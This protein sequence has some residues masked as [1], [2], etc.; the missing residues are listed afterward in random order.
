MSLIS[1]DESTAL[2]RA[3]EAVE[4]ATAGE[5]VVAIVAKSD[6]YSYP[7]ALFASA[8][9]AG[10]GWLVYW[11]LPTISATFVFAGQVVLW[12]AFWWLSGLPWPARTLAGRQQLDLAVDAR[13][14]QVFFERG[15]TETKDRSGVLIFVSE[16]E[17]RVQILADR[18]IHEQV[19]NERWSQE[20]QTV[21]AAIR[22]GHAADG[23]QTVVRE[24]GTLLA[25][26]FPPRGENPNEL[27]NE[28]VRY[29]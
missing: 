8:S 9:A 13:A 24:V 26:A 23:L 1:E 5:L 25:Q 4:T 2:S 12:V 15:L 3:I 27:P 7:R 11:S 16:L 6:D 21:I 28:V 29:R 14:K 10:C 17:H 19:G 20:I 22:S 18:G